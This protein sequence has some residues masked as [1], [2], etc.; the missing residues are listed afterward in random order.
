M[1]FKQLKIL[2]ILHGKTTSVHR[3]CK[4]VSPENNKFPRMYTRLYQEYYLRKFPKRGRGLDRG[5]FLSRFLYWWTAALGMDSE[6]LEGPIRAVEF[7]EA[8][9]KNTRNK[10]AASDGLP[11]VIYFNMPNLFEHL[12]ACG[13]TN[14]QQNGRILRTVSRRVLSL[15]RKD[16]NNGNRN[17]IYRHKAFHCRVTIFYQS[18]SKKL[19]RITKKLIGK[20]QRCIIPT[21]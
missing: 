10:S 16:P 4:T 2:E 3:N 13:L 17:S 15:I 11:Y 20:V 1:K 14:W 9:D 6:M 12:L 8:L 19:E 18:V 5:M 21:S 7:N